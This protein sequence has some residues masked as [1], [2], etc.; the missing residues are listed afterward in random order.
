MH[1]CL[2]VH[3]GPRQPLRLHDRKVGEW[4]IK[5]Y[6]KPTSKYGKTLDRAV[7]CT[8]MIGVEAAVTEKVLEV[9]GAELKRR[10]FGIDQ[11]VGPKYLGQ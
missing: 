5:R 8:T 7:V 10:R 11:S 4:D 2:P 1:V 6:D 9:A 3:S